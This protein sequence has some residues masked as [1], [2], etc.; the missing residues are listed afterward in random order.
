MTSAGKI[1]VS[2]AVGTTAGKGRTS[3]IAVADVR[4]L[5]RSAFKGYFIVPGVGGYEGEEERCAAAA[6]IFDVR[7]N[8]VGLR[9]IMTFCVK[10]EKVVEKV[11]SE[12]QQ[13]SIFVGV[14]I[15]GPNGESLKKWSDQEIKRANFLK[16]RTSV[17][18]L[19]S[20]L[21]MLLLPKESVKEL[22]RPFEAAYKTYRSGKT[23]AGFGKRGIPAIWFPVVNSKQKK[24]YIFKAYTNLKEERRS[25]REPTGFRFGGSPLYRRQPGRRGCQTRGCVHSLR[26]GS[27]RD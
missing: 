18:P 24:E 8:K 7:K 15:T 12:L 20:A 11:F 23:K 2:F 4:A 10:V 27:R 5:F 16:G 22:A 14:D 21:A 17:F 3:N 9:G 25:W 19:P 6:V 1:K 26:P 13:E